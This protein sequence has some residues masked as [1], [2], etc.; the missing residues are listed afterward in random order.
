MLYRAGYNHCAAH[1]NL[2]ILIVT[3]PVRAPDGKSFL[4]QAKYLVR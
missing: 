1:H 3:I 4:K 2:S